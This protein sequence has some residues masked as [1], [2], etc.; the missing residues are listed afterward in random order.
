MTERIVIRKQEKVEYPNNNF[1]IIG[2]NYYDQDGVET[3]VAYSNH[4][5][6]IYTLNNNPQ[7][8]DGTHIWQWAAN[9]Q[10]TQTTI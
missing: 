10:L 9:Y 8:S 2:H 3:L 4:W 5:S 7:N 1:F 6:L